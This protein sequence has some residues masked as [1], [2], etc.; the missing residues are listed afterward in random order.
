[1]TSSTL[2]S[3][4]PTTSTRN[5]ASKYLPSQ[6][7]FFHEQ[8]SYVF[9]KVG[10]NKVRVVTFFHFIIFMK[11]TE[12]I[13]AT[14]WSCLQD[15]HAGRQQRRSAGRGLYE[16]ESRS[17]R[18]RYRSCR[19]SARVLA[20]VTSSRAIPV[21]K[22]VHLDTCACTIRASCL[23]T[24]QGDGHAALSQVRHRPRLDDRLR[25]SRRRQQL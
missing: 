24:R 11:L 20:R 7:F 13:I 5:L 25:R 1:M 6:Y 18:R 3:T 8:Q 16:P 12:W 14:V 4:W 2:P 22:N 21:R 10:G 9:P 23:C 19:V 15:Y 17:L